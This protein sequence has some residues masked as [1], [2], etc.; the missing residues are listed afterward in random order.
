[1]AP[2][3]SPASDRFCTD[4]RGVSRADTVARAEGEER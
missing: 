2:L 1:M 3:P 4:F